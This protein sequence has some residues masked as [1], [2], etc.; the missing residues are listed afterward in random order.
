[1]QEVARHYFVNIFQQQNSDS[2]S[3]IDVINTFVSENDSEMLTAPFCKAEFKDVIFSMHLDKCS[4]LDGFNSGFYQHFWNLCS[5]DIFKECWGWLDTGQFPPD[6]N[7]TI[8]ALTPKG[9]T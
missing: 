7:I 1:M 4:G 3:V 5:D 9:S 2:S 6:L 8:I